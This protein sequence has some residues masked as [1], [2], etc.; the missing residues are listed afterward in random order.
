MVITVCY[1][2]S[3]DISA[4]TEI[5][6]QKYLARDILHSLLEEEDG[7][8]MYAS[9]ISC[10]SSDRVAD[11]STLSRPHGELFIGFQVTPYQKFDEPIIVHT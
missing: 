11:C 5:L 1:A 4:Q 6:S 9:N 8:S 10:P 7:Y 3:I 2:V